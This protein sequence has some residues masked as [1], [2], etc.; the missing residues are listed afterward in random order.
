M[1][2]LTSIFLYFNLKIKIRL[3]FKYMN[4]PI[5]KW[6]LDPLPCPPFHLLRSLLHPFI[7]DPSVSIYSKKTRWSKFAFSLQQ[8]FM[9]LIR[10]IWV[11]L[12]KQQTSKTWGLSW[13]R[14]INREWCSRSEPHRF[15][16]LKNNLIFQL[17]F[18]IKLH[19][20]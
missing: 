13:R 15:L 11:R 4:C 12:G 8:I 10:F 17:N 19:L 14:T 7:P 3:Y 6:I 16:S 9:Y 20:F 5:A 18:I 2:L 1:R